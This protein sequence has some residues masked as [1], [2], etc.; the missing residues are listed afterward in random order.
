MKSTKKDV[1]LVGLMI[2]SN[3]VNKLVS[4]AINVIIVVFYSRAR[5]MV[6]RRLI[7]SFGLR[8]G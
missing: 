3:G 8:S 1:G 7:S 6:L 4:S 2:Q 5:M